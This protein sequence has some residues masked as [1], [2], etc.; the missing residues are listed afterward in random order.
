LRSWQE[1]ITA[2]RL[3]P[4]E[5]SEA[6]CV[7]FY[8]KKMRRSGKHLVVASTIGVAV[9]C[10][11]GFQSPPQPSH[12][13]TPTD[14]GYADPSTCGRCH[15]DVVETYRKTG[16][17]RSFHRVDAADQIEDFTIHNTLYNKASD[18]YYTMIERGGQ[19]YEQ[20]HQID[21]NGKET[22]REEKQ[23]DYVIGS[24]SHSRTYLHRTNEGKLVELPVSWYSEMGGFWGDESRLRPSGSKGFSA[25]YRLRMHV[26]SQRLSCARLSRQKR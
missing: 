16:M 20:R 14:R 8:H 4:E 6:V 5:H 11:V 24:G 25:P 3:A 13:A 26:L 7:P 21:L 22:N 1:P 12:P 18:R 10:M 9:L 23:V 15:A 19:L 2:E 17:G